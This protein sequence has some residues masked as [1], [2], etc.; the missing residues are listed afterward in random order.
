M[1][2]G[3]GGFAT[4]G[5]RTL[6]SLVEGLPE[7]GDRP[8]VLALHKEGAER[9]SYGEFADHALRLAHGLAG[10]GIERGDRVMLFAPNRPEWVVACLAVV[11]AGAVAVPLDAQLGEEALEGVLEGSETK[12][13]F[14]TSEKADLLERLDTDASPVLLDA[15]DDDERGWR[16]LLA[17]TGTVLPEVAPE[18]VAALFYTSGTTGAAKGVPLSHRNIVYQLETLLGADLVDEH[19]R[20][21]LPLPLH[22]VYP[23]V[24][25]MFTP[26]AAG[27]PVVFP[28]SLTGPQ[29]VRA[30]NEGEVTLIV[31]VPR[32]Y[33][34]LYSGIEDRARSGGRVAA[35]LFD[36]ALNLCANL[37]DRTGLDVGRVLMRPLRNRLGPKL[38]TLASG[39]APLDP[40]LARKL[41]ALGWRVG[42][43]YGL[44]ETS[45]LLSLKKP[46]GKKLAS[47]GRPVSGTELRIDPSAMPDEE[48]GE[49]RTDSPYEEGEILARGPGVF[50]GYRDL[51]DKTAEVLTEDGWFRTGDLGYFDDE[52]YLYVT[53]RASTLIVTEGGKNVQPEDVEAVY[54]ESPVI[55]EIGV[56]QKDNR[57][58]AVIVP[59]QS[60]IKNRSD[61][62]EGAI[63]EAV[64]QGA[65]RL[66]SYQRLSD[67]AVTREP[68]EHTQLGK[69]RRH[70]LE[71]RYDRA[72]AGDEGEAPGPIS[73]EE[74]PGEDRAL[75]E[76]DAAREVWELLAR[77]YPDR[78]LTPNTSPQLDLGV[79]SMEWVNL[80]ME[81]GERAGVELDEEAIG[82][83]ETVRDLLREATEAGEAVH[84]ASPVERPEETL[85]ETQ[86]R[87]LEPLSPAESA[88]SRGM[89][90]LNRVL[91]REP[92]R[93]RV[94][95]LENLPKSGPF[96][97][98]PNHVSYLDS[99][100]LAAALDDGR[101]RETYW[102]GW[103]GAA[104][105]NP[106]TRLV[107][108]LARV[109]PIDP[110]RAGTSSLAFGAAVLGRGKN[111][112]WFPEGERSW[113]G[114]L[115]PFKRGLGVLLEHY[116]VPV[117][118]VFVE[119]TYG[120]MPRGS[121]LVRPCRIT[122]TFGQPL[123]VDELERRGEGE[124]PR[125][126]IVE[127][128]RDRIAEMVEGRA[129]DP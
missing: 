26:L 57:L 108:R 121:A 53:G 99:F 112:V 76:D 74:M 105:G 63:R 119:G 70:L 37:R 83:V 49:R 61:D 109:V 42:G 38:K 40:A 12:L 94:R 6:Q 19:D 13:I 39:G 45:P 51:P 102:A 73:V 81:I 28:S 100:A 123:S 43:G 59:E 35:R 91:M 80:T 48:G 5:L 62:A 32:L 84:G 125:D 52:G 23:F 106:V 24:V 126:R 89:F 64:E 116:R 86:K 71:E 3:S 30:L 25:G 85:E 58:V 7:R 2:K 95:G 9:W 22:H 103:V 82:R 14:T 17:D 96:V 4:S 90:A 8:A 18:D 55:G 44:T 78:R 115:G 33:S 88:A 110:A 60:E 54:S 129:C 66:P 1:R 68:L 50:S 20:L 124:E 69:L 104:F 16:R 34:A 29:L 92:F 117:V 10:A 118:P 21:M 36:V 113:T 107:S 111:L 101:L 65:R 75:L 79:D 41:E 15:A 11:R 128:L 98:A 46:D 31:G 56:L 93:L 72:K 97:L 87:R 114:E 77:R 122:V 67:Y 47:V 27:L 120:A 127:A